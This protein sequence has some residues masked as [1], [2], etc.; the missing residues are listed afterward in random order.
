MLSLSEV[1]ISQIIPTLPSFQMHSF[2]HIVSCLFQTVTNIEKDLRS[3]AFVTFKRNLFENILS[4]EA[5]KRN[6]ILP[7]L[8]CNFIPINESYQDCQSIVELADKLG[9]R[10]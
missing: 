2:E 4:V 3:V 8:F 1:I 6:I 7:S 9:E 10:I 5:I